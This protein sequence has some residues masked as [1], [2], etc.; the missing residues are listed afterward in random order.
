MSLIRAA[1]VGKQYGARWIFRNVSFQ[2]TAGER[3]GWVGGNGQGKTSLLRLVTGEDHPSEGEIWRHPGV[4]VSLLKQERGE[5]S[6]TTLAEA[7]LEPFADLLRME[8]SLEK[9]AA[10]VADLDPSDPRTTAFLRDYDEHLEQ[11]RRRG[12]YEIRARAKSTLSG[13]GFAEDAGQRPMRSLSGGELGRLRLA[14]TLLA[15]PDV[16]LLDE[17]TN[18]LDL[19]ATEWL[20][21]FLLGYPGTVVA[22]SHDRVFLEHFADHILHI[23]EGTAFT[24]AAGYEDFLEQREARRELQRKEYEKQ[25]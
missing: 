11:F 15:Q 21:Q 25:Q 22:V 20:E 24:Y 6:T 17:P 12:G 5:G 18:H 3:W 2:L 1:S 13:L 8:A 7:A 23:E 10:T 19:P 14:Q 4:S 16:L 9:T